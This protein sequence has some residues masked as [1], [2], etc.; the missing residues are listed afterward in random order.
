MTLRNKKH[1]S[2]NHFTCLR[3]RHPRNP[4]FLLLHLITMSSKKPRS[5]TNHTMEISA[6][7]LLKYINP[8]WGI[9]TLW[10]INWIILHI[11]E[12]CDPSDFWINRLNP[13]GD[14]SIRMSELRAEPS[15][16]LLLDLWLCIAMIQKPNGRPV[17]AQNIPK[18][19]DVQ[20]GQTCPR[21]WRRQVLGL[22]SFLVKSMSLTAFATAES[23]QPQGLVALRVVYCVRCIDSLPSYTS[24]VRANICQAAW[25]VDRVI[26]VTPRW[27][28]EVCEGFSGFMPMRMFGNC[29]ILCN[30]D[31]NLLAKF[32]LLNKNFYHTLTTNA[33]LLWNRWICK[34]PQTF[35]NISFSQKTKS[36]LNHVE[37]TFHQ[38]ISRLGLKKSFEFFKLQTLLSRNLGHWV[39]SLRKCLR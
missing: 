34:L 16:N 8:S 21:F 35:L 31:F 23:H 29:S 28:L 6:S 32:L 7:V 37:S 19:T 15:W 3:S 18:P 20:S 13:P 27:V 10:I 17:P 4:R 38:L 22:P 26:A 2:P 9:V 36:W 14:L 1:Q 25:A 11:V 39:L 24:R 5:F 12:Y 33:R 30:F